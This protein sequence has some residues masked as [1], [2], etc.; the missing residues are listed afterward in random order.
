MAAPVN[1]STKCRKKVS[2]FAQLLSKKKRIGCLSGP[3]NGS[4]EVISGAQ[5]SNTYSGTVSDNGEGKTTDSDSEAQNSAP[6]LTTSTNVAL[7]CALTESSQ[8]PIHLSRSSKDEKIES[9]LNKQSI[10]QRIGVYKSGDTIESLPPNGLPPL[11]KPSSESS[12]LTTSV[13]VSELNQGTKLKKKNHKRSFSL[14]RGLFSS[15]KNTEKQEKSP[16]SSP[17]LQLSRG[18]W[19]LSRRSVDNIAVSSTGSSPTSTRSQPEGRK[20][21][22]RPSSV[23][24]LSRRDGEATASTDSLARQSLLAAQVLHLIPANKARER[25]FVCP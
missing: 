15:D 11:I 22:S 23:V 13:Q 2:S 21:K 5:S 25:Y 8:T 4:I 10:L 14:S 3:V 24:V 7:C 12:I 1:S 16:E 6:E 19:L 9:D 17:S 18:R 20:R